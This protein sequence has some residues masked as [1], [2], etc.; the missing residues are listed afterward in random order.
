M[1]TPP[2]IIERR[3]EDGRLLA[4]VGLN[5]ANEL[6][7]PF[8]AY[9]EA[10]RPHMRM[11]CRAGQPHGPATLYRDGQPE[12][13]LGFVAG[14]L[15]GEMRTFDA[16]GQAT[17]IVRYV[18]GR[19]HGLME[20]LSPEGRRVLTAEDRNDRLNGAWTE[21]RPDGSIS[22]RMQYKAD[23]LDGETLTFDAAGQP[24]ERTLYAAGRVVEGPQKVTAPAAPVAKAPW[25]RV[26]G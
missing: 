10:G 2:T 15:N 3:A 16:A 18:A 22:R 12:V 20:C 4:T 8:V 14:R 23:L 24:A 1:T 13:Q 26:L 17:S 21:F 6:E 5:P 11:A 25:W 19:R 9:D 7:G